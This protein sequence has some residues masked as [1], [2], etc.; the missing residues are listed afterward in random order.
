M[1]EPRYVDSREA[2]ERR[3]PLERAGFHVEALHVGD[4]KFPEAGGEIVLIE[5]KKL[6]QLLEDLSTG[7]LDRQCYRLCE[8]SPFPILLVEGH[9]RQVNGLLLDSRWTW[10]QVWN[11]LQSLQDMG[12]RL[13]LSTGPEHAVQRICELAEYYGKGEHWS[14]LRRLAGD[15]R[16]GVLCQVHGIGEAKAK[17]LLERY[18]TLEAVA[19]ATEF[20]LAGDG[21]GP[22]LAHRL[23][24][25]WRA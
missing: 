5:N 23:Y 7:Q 14:G 22:I 3:V 16:V 20:D 10:E 9:W 13:Q 25:F 8:A 2:P 12:V 21:I 19:R 4:V 1:L 18:P 24:Q 6:S 15:V 17:G 11:K